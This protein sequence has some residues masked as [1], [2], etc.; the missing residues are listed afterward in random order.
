[1]VRFARIFGQIIIIFAGMVGTYFLAEFI[2]LKV[3]GMESGLP[4]WSIVIAVT[5][6]IGIV[7]LLI[8]A[9]ICGF[10]GKLC[11]SI[12]NRA[13]K[14]S[15]RDLV[16]GTV[17]LIIGLIIAALLGSS[18]SSLRFGPYIVLLFSL[19]MGYIGL[20]VGLKRSEDLLSS[21]VRG[22]Q[23]RE[24]SVKEAAGGPSILDTSVIID[25]RI[26]D[27]FR[28]G[29][30][31]GP[32]VVP[33]FVL[34][35]LKRVADSSDP[36]KKSRGRRGLDILND[37]RQEKENAIVVTEQDYEDIKEVD[38]KLIRLALDMKGRIF[39]NDFNLNK[40]AQVQSVKVLNINDLANAIK[41][42]VLPGE[43]MVVRVIR[44]GKE[45][46]QGIAYLEDGTM[47]V[48][49][50]GRHYVGITLSVVVTSV[51]QTSAGR[52]IFA[53]PKE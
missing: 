14:M 46:D 44:E 26:V 34:D 4:Y 5:V 43:E 39:T 17:G 21:L 48:V 3:I 24:K 9:Y 16:G 32:L 20:V 36:I 10:I 27:V 53:K 8:S 47:V 19:F 29:F 6:I 28:T 50:S 30:I 38:L 41:T 15:M 33:N 49:E 13:A 25:G 23:A 40:M 31:S 52:M 12:V 45:E 7:L 18:I 11:M 42:V 37:L 35:E 22:R 2:L 51:L 1:M